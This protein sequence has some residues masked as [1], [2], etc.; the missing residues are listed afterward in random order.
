MKKEKRME[1]AQNFFYEME[2]LMSALYC[3]WQDEKEYEDIEDYMKVVLPEVV[4]IGGTFDKMKKRPFG[5][6]YKLADATY[7]IFVRAND[8]GYKRIA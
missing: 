7:Q 1:I 8:Y 6:T 2:G 3:R 4:K 5:F